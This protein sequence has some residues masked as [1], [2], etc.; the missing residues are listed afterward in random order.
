IDG[1]ESWVRTTRHDQMP[2][3]TCIAQDIRSDKTHIWY[4]GTGEG[5]GSSSGV[6]GDG[7]F[8]STNNGLTWEQLPSTVSGTP[9]QQDAFDFVWR[10]DIDPS[11]QDSSIV[12]AAVVGGIYRSADGGTTWKR[13]LGTAVSATASDIT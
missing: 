3:V 13:V 5:S 2:S 11:R 4:Y 9:Q 7:I 1:G 12:Y 10:I 6:F 8:K